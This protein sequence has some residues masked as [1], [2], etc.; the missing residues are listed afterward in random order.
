MAQMEL[1][2][3]GQVLGDWEVM[4]ELTGELVVLEQVFL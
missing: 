4:L 2:A 3:A 1:Q